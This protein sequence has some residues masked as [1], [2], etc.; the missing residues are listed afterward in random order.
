MQLAEGISIFQ[1]SSQRTNQLLNKNNG[2]AFETLTQI[3][4]VKWLSKVAGVIW[5]FS[6]AKTC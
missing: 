1:S 5:R 3:I 2:A 6:V 4:Q